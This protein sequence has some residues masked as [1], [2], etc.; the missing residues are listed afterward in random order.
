[1]THFSLAVLFRAVALVAVGI[2]LLCLT[3]GRENIPPPMVVFWPWFGSGALIGAGLFSPFKKPWLGAL[4]G[5]AVQGIIFYVLFA[6][7]IHGYR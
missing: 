1:M 5:V 2:S 6:L 3:F 7:I 4:V